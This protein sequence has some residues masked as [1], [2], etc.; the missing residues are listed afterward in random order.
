M[1]DGEV[2]NGSAENQEV[3]PSGKKSGCASLLDSGEDFTMLDDVE[4]DVDDDLPPLED[5]GGGKK[6]DSPT[7]DATKADQ[8][9]SIEQE[10]WL[11]VLGTLLPHLYCGSNSSLNGHYNNTIMD[12][13]PGH[14]FLC[15]DVAVVE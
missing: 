12:K 2:V 10:E 8:A 15:L 6:K 13:Y 14:Y 5:A 3:A 11:D 4:D 7:K 9:P 1:A